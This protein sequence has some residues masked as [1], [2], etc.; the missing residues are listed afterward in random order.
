MPP[1]GAMGAMPPMGAMGAMPP[2]GAMGAMPPM[3]AMPQMGGPSGDLGVPMMQN[4]M[5]NFMGVQPNQMGMPNQ[6]GGGKKNI[7]K[8]KLTLDKNFFF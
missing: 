6:M 8:Y 1:M 7:Q 4:P 3:G 2:M 5:A